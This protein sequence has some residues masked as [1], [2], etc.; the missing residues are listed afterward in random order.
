MPSTIQSPDLYLICPYPNHG[1]LHYK[2]KIQA[3]IDAGI[4][5][6]QLRFKYIFQYQ[7]HEKLIDAMLQLCDINNC[8]LLIN[9]TIEYATKIGVDGVHMRSSI[10]M[11]L[12]NKPKH[13]NNNLLISASCHNVVEIVHASK[14]QIDFAVLSPIKQTS[15]RKASKLLGW[16]KFHSL[17][18]HASIPIYAL[19]G[20]QPE[21]MAL[22]YKLGGKGIAVLGGFWDADKVDQR[23]FLDRYSQIIQSGIHAKQQ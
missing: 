21:D 3:C 19:G 6:F 20:M 11:Q 22:A 15:D 1:Y 17:I 8:K 2:K 18:K 13:S 23:S 14:M 4:S 12:N 5:L 7:R 16:N 9:S 10:L